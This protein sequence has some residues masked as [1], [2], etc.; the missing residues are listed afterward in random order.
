MI[1]ANCNI[2]NGWLETAS[3]I[4]HG[5]E[6]SSKLEVFWG[7]IA[8]LGLLKNWESDR[9]FFQTVTGKRLILQVAR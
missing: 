8:L 3:P 2:A 1:L 9:V 7:P 5:A 4:V 6:H